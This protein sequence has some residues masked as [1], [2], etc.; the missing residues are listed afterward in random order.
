ML[1]EKWELQIIKIPERNTAVAEHPA[2]G[3][4]DVVKPQGADNP[5]DISKT[6]TRSASDYNFVRETTAANQEV[7]VVPSHPPAD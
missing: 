1:A 5:F 7:A 6:M 4:A 3:L 2:L